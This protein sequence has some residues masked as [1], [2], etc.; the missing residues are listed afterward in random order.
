M[1]RL[2]QLTNSL[3][4]YKCCFREFCY[5]FLKNSL[6]K[7]HKDEQVF[8]K[9]PLLQTQTSDDSFE[10]TAHRSQLLLFA[11]KTMFAI[12]RSFHSKDR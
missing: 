5:L 9:Q 4:Y 3:S 11:V 6:G 2:Q 8:I 1:L 7:F 12:F 10:K